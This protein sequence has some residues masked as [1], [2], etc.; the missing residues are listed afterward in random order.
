MCKVRLYGIGVCFIGG[1]TVDSRYRVELA[2]LK[3]LR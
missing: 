3:Q 1:H 2:A